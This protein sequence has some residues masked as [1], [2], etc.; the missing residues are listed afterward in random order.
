MIYYFIRLGW[1]SPTQKR[2]D[3]LV[4]GVLRGLPKRRYQMIYNPRPRPWSLGLALVALLF[5]VEIVLV[6]YSAIA[7]AKPKAKA[8]PAATVPTP[9][10]ETTTDNEAVLLKVVCDK[11]TLTEYRVTCYVIQ[12]YIRHD[13]PPSRIQ[14]MVEALGCYERRE[15]CTQG[16]HPEGTCLAEITCPA[17]YIKADDLPPLRTDPVPKQK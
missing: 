4:E 2:S 12:N 16:N 7:D 6:A 14:Q 5:I 3:S 10:S 8:T 9:V 17:Y 1:S 11:Q 13:Y 15:D